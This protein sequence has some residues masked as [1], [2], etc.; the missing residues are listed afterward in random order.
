MRG[1]DLRPEPCSIG[2]TRRPLQLRAALDDR[3]RSPPDQVFRNLETLV[4]RLKTTM[5]DS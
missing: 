5:F 4:S 2:T 3:A 1:A